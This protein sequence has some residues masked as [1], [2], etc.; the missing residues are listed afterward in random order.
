MMSTKGCLVTRKGNFS[1]DMFP[2]FLM[3]PVKKCFECQYRIFRCLTLTH[4]P[5]SFPSSTSDLR[6][7]HKRRGYAGHVKKNKLIKMETYRMRIL[8]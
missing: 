2:M 4:P 8:L 6:S 1:S 5:T 3:H 7:L